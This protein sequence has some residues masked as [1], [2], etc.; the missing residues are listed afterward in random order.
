MCPTEE[1]VQEDLKALEE[2]V[3]EKPVLEKE[4][5]DLDVEEVSEEVDSEEVEFEGVDKVEDIK[6]GEEKKYGI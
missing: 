4:E 2:A 1:E 5:G 6:K 3:S